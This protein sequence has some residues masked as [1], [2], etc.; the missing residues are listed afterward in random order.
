M[1]HGFRALDY[2]MLSYE[3]KDQN[4]T[5]VKHKLDLIEKHLINLELV[6]D[7]DFVINENTLKI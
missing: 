6:Y 1:T 3:T 5:M 7:N 2:D 4:K